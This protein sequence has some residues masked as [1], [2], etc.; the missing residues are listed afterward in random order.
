MRPLSCEG[1]DQVANIIEQGMTVDNIV[2]SHGRPLHPD[3]CTFFSY[4][5]QAKRLILKDMVKYFQYN[6][7][8]SSYVERVKEHLR[9]NHTY[10][11]PS[12]YNRTN[13]TNVTNVTN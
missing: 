7:T 8:V 4:H 9:N 12:R 6:G 5:K 13:V 2:D 3:A 1:I 10:Y 11:I